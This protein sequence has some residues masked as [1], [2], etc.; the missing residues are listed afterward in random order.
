MITKN[1]QKH[2]L[3]SKK[4][5]EL[6]NSM[7]TTNMTNSYKKVWY[8]NMS[9]KSYACHTKKELLYSFMKNARN[10]LLKYHYGSWLE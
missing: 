4:E 8:R 7:Y 1:K 9:V 2:K 6:I 3:E 5:F 10:E